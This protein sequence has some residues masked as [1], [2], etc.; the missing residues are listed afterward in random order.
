MSALSGGPSG[1]LGLARN[2]TAVREDRQSF[3]TRYLECARTRL[4]NQRG[5]GAIGDGVH[6]SRGGD[7]NIRRTAGE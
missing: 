1:R 2:H 4:R 5:Y 3:R 6:S 7:G